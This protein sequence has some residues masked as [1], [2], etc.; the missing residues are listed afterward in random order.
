MDLPTKISYETL[1][2]EIQDA[3]PRKSDSGR[4]GKLD[5]E[6]DKVI[7]RPLISK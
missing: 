7:L 3:K 1:S 6:N 2:L 4:L 5:T